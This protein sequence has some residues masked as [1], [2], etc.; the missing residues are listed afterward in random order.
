VLARLEALLDVLAAQGFEPLQAAY[1]DA[2]LHS[3]QQARAQCMRRGAG[4]IGMLAGREAALGVRG[5]AEAQR[6]AARAACSP[7]PGAHMRSFGTDAA[8]LYA[9][10]RKA[11]ACS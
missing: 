8:A 9:A 7:V 3:G 6:R 5:G 2:W 10:A 4:A 1:L 11:A